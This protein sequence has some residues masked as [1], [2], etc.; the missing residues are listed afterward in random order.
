MKTNLKIFVVCLLAVFLSFATRSYAQ[1]PQQLIHFWDFN[2][3]MP[4]YGGTAD[5]LGTVWSYTPLSSP[6]SRN[7]DSLEHTGSMFAV[8]SKLVSSNPRIVYI[9]PHAIQT[10]PL[11]A[12][13]HDSIIDNGQGGATYY[14]YS[15]Q[16]YNY[17]N[18]SDTGTSET[19]N[20]FVRT[21]N[22]SENC[23]AYVYMPTTG[24][25]NIHVNFAITASSSKGNKYD[26]FQY[27]TNGGTSWNS[28][29]RGQASVAGFNNA[30]WS[31]WVTNTD[32]LLVCSATTTGIDSSLWCPIAI[33]LSSVTTANNNPNFMLRWEVVGTGSNGG[34]GN[35]RYDNFAVLGDSATT[36]LV[37]Y[38][39]N[40]QNV[41]PCSGGD[42]GSA[43]VWAV[44]GTP[45]YTY[46]WSSNV[47]NSPVYGGTTTDSAY[48]LAAGTYTVNV[49]DNNSGYYFCTVTIL[50]PAAVTATVT[51]QISPTCNGSSNGS[52]T[53]NAT[54]GSS[55]YTYLWSTGNTNKTATGLAA[56]TYTCTVTDSKGCTGTVSVNITQPS[57]ISVSTSSSPVTCT[58]LGSASV[59]S[60]SGGTPHKVGAPYTYLW[61]T[62]ATTA[63]IGG[64][65]TGSYTVTVK[66]SNSCTGTAVVTVGTSGAVGHTTVTN[67]SCN[68]GSNGAVSVTVTGGSS[69]YTYLWS[70]GATTT[71]ISGLT[72]GTY[73]VTIT[74]SN[75]CQSA[76]TGTVTQPAV[77]YDTIENASTQ[78]VIHYWDFNTTA[79][80]GGGG[81]DSLGTS[82]FPLPP[83]VSVL[84][85]TNPHMIYSHPS[86]TA[87][88]LDN[89]SGG[90]G[91]NDLPI[92]GNDTG[93]SAAGNL[94][95]RSRN[96]VQG[97][98]FMWYIPTT[99]YQNIVLD[100]ALSASSGKGAQFL[101]FSYSKDGGSTWNNLTSA[102]DTFNVGGIA[103]PDSMTAINAITSASLW[104]PVHIDL[105]SDKGAN[106]N[107]NL[108]FQIQF[109]G[110]NVT[111]TSGNNRF[112]NVS[113]KGQQLSHV[114]CNGSANDTGTV[115]V[116][117]GTSPY[118]Y[119]WSN[120]VT[121]ATDNTLPGGTS[122]VTVTDAHGC[123]SSA[124]VSVYN[125]PALV[126]DSISV[127][128]GCYNSNNGTATA[129]S[130]GGTPPYTYL[131]SNGSVSNVDNNLAPGTYTVTVTDLHG[132]TNTDS[133]KVVNAT[134][135]TA[136]I[137][138]K[139]V[140]CY[141]DSNGSASIVVTGGSAPYKYKWFNKVKSD[142]IT[143]LKIGTYSVTITDANGCTL[144][145]SATITQ[146]SA[147]TATTTYTVSTC[148]NSN[149]SASV[150]ASGGTG[151]YTY[152]W[153]NGATTSSTSSLA[154]GTYTVTITDA[155]GCVG[156]PATVTLPNPAPSATITSETNDACNASKTGSATVTASGGTSPYTYSWSPTGG[157]APVA[158]SLGAGTY[159]V[160]V[161]DHLGC[162]TTTSV[163]IS[164]PAAIR[165]SIA[166]G[167]QVN[168]S[169]YGGNNGSVTIGVKGG[170][171]PYFFS[172]TPSVS[173]GAT[174][175]N[176]TAGTYKV[177]VS[178]ANGCTGTTLTIIIT[179]P[180][181]LRD[182]ISTMKNVT[183]NGGAN[184]SATLGVKGGTGPYTYSWSTGGTSN[185]VSALTAGSYSVT[186]T[187]KNG[188][189]A[190]ATVTI[191]Q[192]SAVRDS[193]TAST[194]DACNGGKTGSASVGVTG[195]TSP[196]T[197]AWTPSGGTG[198]TATGLGAGS[199]T[200]TVKDHNG[201][202]ATANAVITQPSKIR[203][204][205]VTSSVVNNNCN[206]TTIGTATIGVKDGT[207]AYTYAWSNGTT[208]ATASGL[209]AGVYTVAVDDANG[210][211][212]TTV[213]VTITQP[214]LLRDSIVAT[215]L[216]NVTCNGGTNGAAT[217]GVKGGTPTYTYKWST[218]A[219][220]AAV[221]TFAAGSYT[222]T[223]TDKN[224]CTAVATVTI[225]QPSAVR[226]SITAT[227]ND[228][229][230][231]GKTG[232][233]T[234]G[235]KGGT[236]PYTYAWSP[237][238]GTSAT[239]VSLAAGTYTVTVKDH[240][241]CSNATAKATITQPSKIRDSLVAALTTEV[242]CYGGSN[243]SET[244]GVK[245]GTPPYT[246]TWSPSVSISATASGLTAGSYSVV[247][248]DAN[249]C[250]GTALA[251]T[252]TQPTQLRDSITKTTCSLTGNGSAYV[253]YKGGTPTYTFLW[254]PS[255]QTAYYATKLSAGSYT[256]TITDKKGCQVNA[257]ATVV[258]CSVGEIGENPN[259]VDNI[260]VTESKVTL[261]PNPNS[262]EFQINGLEEGSTVE[263]YNTLG[264]LIRTVSVKDV[265][266]QFNTSDLPNGMYLIRII[267]QDGT[268]IG[269]PKMIKQW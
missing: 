151:P 54:G 40:R 23:Y 264:M 129:Y 32:S 180:A 221:T 46:S 8:Y 169:C 184:G 103:R 16:G 128:L 195:G 3:T 87:S 231:G 88:L 117:G 60:A 255:G 176:L 186:V 204:S 52:A 187:D 214:T 150:T 58:T 203:D 25:Q 98:S 45:P 19:G 9:R 17:M 69:P 233:A 110:S 139:S 227:T 120:G 207:P 197:Y 49:N 152:S 39:V 135:L 31:S 158:S 239:G 232:T 179:Q 85:T 167:S 243:G 254:T 258:S 165:D 89:G 260:N 224:G 206:G 82:A 15:G 63:T 147:I 170:T 155:N 27:S 263:I 44:G 79:P 67:V 95:V 149:G 244:V 192:P 215:S 191:T 10:T 256:V 104:Y 223:V 99:G 222:V 102:M 229:C 68:G 213:T 210:C 121:A 162:A 116:T 137:T 148:S 156:I 105:S 83:N 219:T 70:N 35:G 106:N 211:V 47:T 100:W 251:T 29:P 62:G 262:G 196:Y 177:A 250:A 168:V 261:Y 21:R 109:G 159:T 163:V 94:F 257:V 48:G 252:I 90:A 253:G 36:G 84:P 194:N 6:P 193:I 141:G 122:S 266:M 37:A 73:T 154:P 153:S 198:A 226:D 269:Q 134:P 86:S 216:K 247:I 71:S 166:H 242:S 64:L 12:T 124:S 101:I 4:M 61:S 146:P 200:V 248:N 267:S 118:T 74:E 190:V 127:N 143:G 51:S 11:A 133:V 59:T 43:R 189:T 57:T 199:Y 136:V 235:V 185:I 30:R 205:L 75:G 107:P 208:T 164:Q 26:I 217:V 14:S 236:S 237:S 115:V 181:I 65:G 56:G 160:T 24:Y 249:G 125:P 126:V 28:I 218:G 76:A 66:D 123:T 182:S 259:G 77:L 228:A 20:C 178:D 114:T 2:G 209:A 18:Y 241:G 1:Q 220:T 240:N 55:V 119:A 132:C 268:I 174:A 38:C 238:G 144:V 92:A 5:S 93:S 230:N 145:D 175:N 265:H 142:T 97:S 157:T 91:V 80:A 225:T 202:S 161:K 140:T 34:S 183:C 41:T 246:F 33:N 173:T 171:A 53:V 188:C 245:D 78:Q 108:I 72:A 7:A 234:V 50:Q 113:V 130:G 212:G 42:N 201:C 112:D 131:W 13:I 111:L 81:G 138:P 22:P 96:P 172:W